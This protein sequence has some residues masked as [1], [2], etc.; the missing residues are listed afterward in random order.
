MLL[1][2]LGVNLKSNSTKKENNINEEVN[3]KGFLRG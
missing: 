3:C 1:V 2:I